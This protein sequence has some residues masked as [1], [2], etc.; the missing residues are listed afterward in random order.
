MRTATASAEATVNG[1]AGGAKIAARS[2]HYVGGLVE[3]AD[4]GADGVSAV[5]P[6]S[7]DADGAGPAI[8]G[9]GDVANCG[10]EGW[11]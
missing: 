10:Q 6:Q 2:P 11:G 3:A 1:T 9:G 8:A 4:D 7:V 5:S